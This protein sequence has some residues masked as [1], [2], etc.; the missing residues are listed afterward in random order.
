MII[1]EKCRRYTNLSGMRINM[2]QRINK[3]L[4]FVADLTYTHI[5]V[6]VKAKDGSRFAVVSAIEPHTAFNPFRQILLGKLIPYIQ[7]PLIKKCMDNKKSA[8]D[9]ASSISAALS[10][11]TRSPLSTVT[12]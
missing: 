12:K 3:V 7:E 2:L 6:Y 9:G 11:C 10:T 1:S 5:A 8:T 4:P